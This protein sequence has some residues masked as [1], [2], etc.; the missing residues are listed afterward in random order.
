LDEEKMAKSKAQKIQMKEEFT[1]SFNNAAA[2]IA[3]DYQGTTTEDLT[4]LR[5]KLKEIGCG[6]KVVKN[7]VAIKAIEDS[8]DSYEELKK[9]FS[10]SYC[11][12]LFR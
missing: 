1:L 8:C 11:C 4:A 9:V 3:A 7:R 2:A 10:R 6:L 12:C 5:R